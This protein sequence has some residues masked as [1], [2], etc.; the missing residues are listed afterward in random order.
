MT[1]VISMDRSEGD[2][3]L[4][5]SEDVTSIKAIA[6]NAPE[7]KARRDAVTMLERLTGAGEDRTEPQ[8]I[9]RTM[10][11]AGSVGLTATALIA[12]LSSFNVGVVLTGVGTGL[13]LALASERMM[14]AMRQVF[15]KSGLDRREGFQTFALS[16]PQVGGLICAAFYFNMQAF[17]V[18]ALLGAVVLAMLSGWRSGEFGLRAIQLRMEVQHAR[19]ELELSETNFEARLEEARL[20]F[21]KEIE[22][23]RKVAG[24]EDQPLKPEQIAAE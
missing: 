19:A 1:N 6:D 16:A 22:H 13:A 2:N 10:L 4:L 8:R 21:D 11:I 24:A 17:G 3:K 12:T 14:C 15:R 18:L 5:F 7:L 9:S 20:H 23:L